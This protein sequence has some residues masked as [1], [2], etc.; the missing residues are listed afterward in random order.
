MVSCPADDG[1]Y[2]PAEWSRH[3]RTWMLWPSE[4]DLQTVVSDIVRTVQK[5]E[6]V[7]M[8]ACPQRTREAGRA[9][10]GAQIWSV[11]FDSTQLRRFGPTFLV[12]GKGGEAAVDWPGWVNS[13]HTEEPRIRTSFSHELLSAAEVRRFRA[14]ITIEDA[15]FCA[16][17]EGTLL[18]LTDAVLNSER[19]PNLE[20][21]S[22]Y[23]MLCRWLG[24][25]RVIWID[26]QRQNLPD[27][28][29]AQEIRQLAVFTRPGHVLV[30]S[31]SSKRFSLGL[32][33]V[34]D[35]LQRA[36]DARGETLSVRRIPAWETGKDFAP[37]TTFYV[38]NTAV[39]VPQYGNTALDEKACSILSECFPQRVIQPVDCG[40]LLHHGMTLSHILQYQPARL[41]DR[42]KAT[43]LPKSSWHRPVPD[44]VGLLEEYIAKADN[45]N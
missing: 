6:P 5:F 27:V 9:C 34:A 15:N 19:N 43:L 40:P 41:L 39:L 8:V 7:N 25:T 30:S 45:S 18:C 4:E 33:M 36:R 3:A 44:Y 22:A 1:F 32:D 29:A 38:L 21:L 10:H 11:K 28:N 31:S 17:G 35:R 20:K 14:P 26:T 42:S 16:D 37:Y 2:L 24:V 23:N 12:D 13:G